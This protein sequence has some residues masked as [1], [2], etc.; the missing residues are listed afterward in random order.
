LLQI[1]FVW[2]FPIILKNKKNYLDAF[3]SENTLKS[4][5]YRNSER[6]LIFH[7]WVW[8]KALWFLDF[9]FLIIFKFEFFLIRFGF[10]FTY[11]MSKVI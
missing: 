9:R 10:V 5:H 1:K 3:L 4:N 7:V 8:I 2:C 11:S 6:A